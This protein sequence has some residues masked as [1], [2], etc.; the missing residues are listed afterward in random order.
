[1]AQ[2]SAEQVLGPIVEDTALPAGRPSPVT[3]SHCFI[4]SL[5]GWWER[6]NGQRH[7]VVQVR[8]GGSD[9]LEYRARGMR[10]GLPIVFEG[11]SWILNG[12]RL[13]VA[14]SRGDV[15]EWERPSGALRHWKRVTMSGEK[16]PEPQTPPRFRHQRKGSLSLPSLSKTRSHCW[17]LVVSPS[18]KEVCEW[19]ASP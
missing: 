2:C 19:P 9:T 6:D 7:E 13:N 15:L 18:L 10:E 8:H 11:G 12:F 14:Q 1:M 17:C 5:T 16:D 4:P 3:P